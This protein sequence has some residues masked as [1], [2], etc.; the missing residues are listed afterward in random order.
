MWA[1]A[2][3]CYFPSQDKKRWFKLRRMWS[4][5]PTARSSL[6]TFLKDVV[7][8]NLRATGPSR[9]RTLLRKLRGKL[10]TKIL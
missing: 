9:V 6:L 1:S 4:Q 5:R 3:M 8:N 2:R 10:E 7:I